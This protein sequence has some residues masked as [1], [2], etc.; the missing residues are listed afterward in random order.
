M[1]Q[2]RARLGAGQFAFVDRLLDSGSTMGSTDGRA[3]QVELQS[4]PTQ[5]PAS[6]LQRLPE[7]AGGAGIASARALPP[8]GRGGATA[9]DNDGDSGDGGTAG[10]RRGGRLGA[11]RAISPMRAI[12][13]MRSSS[14]HTSPA[15]PLGSASGGR[16]T[17]AMQVVRGAETPVA[18]DSLQTPVVDDT[19]PPGAPKRR[20][21]T[22]STLRARTPPRLAVPP[23]RP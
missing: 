2:F 12:S 15:R 21:P 8:L 3:P 19:L 7:R 5:Q 11:M 20:A 18:D 1:G 16:P 22:L 23:R 10:G 13:G 9:S 6:Q 17:A 4:A 14:K